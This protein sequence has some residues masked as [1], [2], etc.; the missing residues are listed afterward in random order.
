MHEYLGK[1]LKITVV[2]EIGRPTGDYAE[3]FAN[4]IGFTVRNHAPLDVEY[5]KD[6]QPADIA[7]LVDRLYVSDTPCSSFFF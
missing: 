1:K 4:E 5:W 6:V 3:M 2:P 7:K